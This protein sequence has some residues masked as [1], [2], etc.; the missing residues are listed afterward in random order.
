M[1]VAVGVAHAIAGELAP[2]LEFATTAKEYSVPF[3][4]PLISQVVSPLVVH[5]A[6]PG[7]AKTV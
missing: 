3:V 2:K 6:P 5:V 7:E 4:S 1:T